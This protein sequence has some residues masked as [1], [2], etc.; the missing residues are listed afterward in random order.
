MKH[1]RLFEEFTE[2]E[3]KYELKKSLDLHLGNWRCMNNLD[4]DRVKALVNEL[5]K[6]GFECSQSKENMDALIEKATAVDWTGYN[7]KYTF[8]RNQFS[9]VN[10]NAILV[11]ED[12]F[13][14]KH[15]FRGINM[16]KFGV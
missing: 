4:S 9:G 7:D 8:H 15:E 1:V 11:F 2:N 3:I 10:E 14:P 13:K 6:A 5:E 12:Y 16:R